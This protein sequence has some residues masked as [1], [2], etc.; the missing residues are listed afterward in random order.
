MFVQPYREG[1][2]V[3]AANAPDPIKAKADAVCTG[4]NDQV[5]IN[6]MLATMQTTPGGIMGAGGLLYLSQ[7]RFEL[8]GPILLRGMMGIAGAG[9]VSTLLAQSPEYHG[10]I[11]QLDSPERITGFISIESL[12][13]IGNSPKLEPYI[14]SRISLTTKNSLTDLSKT[15]LP[16][17]LVGG[18]VE[19]V[20]DGSLAQILPIVT[21]AENTI[22]VAGGWRDQPPSG[23][24]YRVIGSGIGCYGNAGGYMRLRDLYIMSLGGCGVVL[25]NSPRT[26]IEG[27]YFNGT[28]GDGIR[29]SPHMGKTLGPRIFNNTINGMHG[30][31]IRFDDAVEGAIITGNELYGV[32]KG[33]CGIRCNHLSKTII[34][35][36]V[37]PC[38][39]TTTVH[40]KGKVTACTAVSATVAG[41]TW[42]PDIWKD[43]VVTLRN[44]VRLITANSYSTIYFH[45]QELVSA[46]GDELIIHH[47]PRG[48]VILEGNSR[49]NLISGNVITSDL[50]GNPEPIFLGHET[51]HNVVVSN[52]ITGKVI[53]LGVDNS[54]A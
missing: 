46:V 31:A 19:I 54:I 33:S 25:S 27:C 23:T 39:G 20:G 5:V 44:Q 29:V 41:Q 4:T 53:N 8:G 15:W 30:S 37:F 32:K 51:S 18:A 7:G 49:D 11:L 28:R 17:S 42:E 35:N 47:L 10:D 36:N 43:E 38:I 52:L 21:N 2:F 22:I 16:G 26:S 12:G 6:E 48:G 3:A 13:L 1:L 40:F 14:E 45:H 50:R 24:V 9:M 34:S